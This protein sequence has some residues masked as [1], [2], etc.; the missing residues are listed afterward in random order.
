MFELEEVLNSKRQ[1]A[2]IK[3][4]GVGGAGGNVINNMI[5]SSI[6]EVEFIAINTDA[7]AL[8][9]SMAPYKVQIGRSITRGLG[10]GSKP[11][12]G[13]DSALEDKDAIAEALDGADMVF[14][15]A[16]MG[17]GTGTGAA[18]VVAEMARNTGALT[19]AVVTKPF[20]YEGGKRALNAEYGLAELQGKVDTLI[21]IPNDR[22]SMVVEKG[23]SL[24]Q[25]FAVAN[26]VLKHAVQGISDLIVVPGLINLDFADVKTI[27]KDAGR[28]VIGMGVGSAQGGAHDAAKKAILNPLLENN[29]IEGAFGILINITGGL[30]LALSD[31]QEA[32]APVFDCADEEA[33]IIVGAVVDPDVNDEVRVT[34]IA[35]GFKQEEASPVELPQ[36]KKWTGIPREPSTTKGSD[37]VLAKSLELKAEE[38][39]KR[40]DPLDVPAFLRKSA[41]PDVRS[42]VR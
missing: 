4:V 30:D 7:Q 27:V 18:P 5:A 23:T 24:L 19:V 3:V 37:R 22:I 11:E 35:T 13:R 41:R 25:S 32:A 12:A 40:H 17:G 14:I 6:R 20:F 34:V 16:G 9:T 26:D 31:V 28:A 29:S 8:E 15:T 2:R 33:N 21:V 36:V 10:A 1:A 38:L 39:A 42:L